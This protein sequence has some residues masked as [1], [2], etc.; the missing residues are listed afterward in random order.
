MEKSNAMNRS[1]GFV[2]R[3]RLAPREVMGCIDCIH[4]ADLN[5]SG[6][7]LSQAIK[8]GVIVALNTLRESGAIPTRDGFEYTEMTQPFLQGSKESKIAVGHN[9]VMQDARDQAMDVPPP[10]IHT[11][12]RTEVT[13]TEARWMRKKVELLIKQ[14]ADPDNFGAEEQKQLARCISELEKIHRARA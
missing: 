2:L 3:L 5:I 7:S 14:D 6:M 4:A 8:R 9:F 11:Q 10:S 12:Q 1:V 13:P